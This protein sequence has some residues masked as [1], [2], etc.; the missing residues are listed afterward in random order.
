M[1]LK[2]RHRS[3]AAIAGTTV[4]ASLG[5][6]PVVRADTG[7]LF[8]TELLGTGY[9]LADK[10]EA[11]GKCGEGKC[12]A[13]DETKDPGEGKCGASQDKSGTEG[14]CGASGESKE[15]AEGKCGEGKCG[16][17]A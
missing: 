17:S 3:I 4:I 7:N 12:G 8:A 11:E 13:S 5:A 2:S 10:H 14:Q 16:G 9:M 1:K 15:D 6:V